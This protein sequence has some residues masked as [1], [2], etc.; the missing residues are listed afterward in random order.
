M[1]LVI[2]CATD[3]SNTTGILFTYGNT[4]P[5]QPITLLVIGTV[6]VIL[7]TDDNTGYSGVTLG[8]WWAVT[9]GPM[10]G[11]T[12]FSADTALDV[13]ITARVQTFLIQTCL[14]RRA[15]AIN[16]AFS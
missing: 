15:V 5:I 16:R 14:I 7:A 10:K 4:E 11:D 2:P 6:I 12:A 3:G 13:V 1:V 8:T 9:L